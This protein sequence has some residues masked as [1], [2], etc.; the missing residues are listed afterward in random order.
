MSFP[1]AQATPGYRMAEL[2]FLLVLQKAGSCFFFCAA[3]RQLQ[4]SEEITTRRK[5]K[6]TSLPPSPSCLLPFRSFFLDWGVLRAVTI[7]QTHEVAP[8]LLL[9]L[10]RKMQRPRRQTNIRPGAAVIV[11]ET[12][13]GTDTIRGTVWILHRVY[14][15]HW[16]AIA[17]YQV[18]RVF[19]H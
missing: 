13:C 7:R 18:M 14:Y 16:P 9:P 2:T 8:A 12:F 17:S 1:A 3:T 11:P 19:M 4:R 5:K 15:K 6:T 10:T